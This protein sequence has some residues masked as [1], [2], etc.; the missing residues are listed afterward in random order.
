MEGTRGAGERLQDFG[1]LWGHVSKNTRPP[2]G[3]R[4]FCI[5]EHP[6]HEEIASM[7]SRLPKRQVTKISQAAPGTLKSNS[8]SKSKGQFAFHGRSL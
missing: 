7:E 3:G 6:P 4:P 8:K 2:L 5:V 1:Q